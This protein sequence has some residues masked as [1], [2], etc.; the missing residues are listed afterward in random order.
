MADNLLTNILEASGMDD[1]G[2]RRGTPNDPGLNFTMN[3]SSAVTCLIEIGF[4]DNDTDNAL[5]DANFEA[6]AEAIAD[7]IMAW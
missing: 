5:F 2:V 4:I 6:I 7:G 3:R 1:R